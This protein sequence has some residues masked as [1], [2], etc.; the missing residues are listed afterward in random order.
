MYK[1]RDYTNRTKFENSVSRSKETLK[2]KS[3]SHIVTRITVLLRYD[4][5]TAYMTWH[6]EKLLL[7]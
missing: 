5:H 6:Y 4:P 1:A 3:N 2:V 7:L